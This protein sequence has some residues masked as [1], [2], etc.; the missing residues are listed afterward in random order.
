MTAPEG[1]A[2]PG[3]VCSYDP[4]PLAGQPIG[5]FHCP[6]CGCMVLAGME[7]PPCDPDECQLAASDP[8]PKAGD[9]ETGGEG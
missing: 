6:E 3:V 8:Q 1:R 4:R 9:H 7:H 5:M 2:L